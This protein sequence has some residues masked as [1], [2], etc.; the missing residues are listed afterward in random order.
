M[1]EKKTS[2]VKSN[3]IS[4]MSSTVG[5]AAG[6]V[7]G[8]V[9]SSEVNAAEVPVTP[10]EEREVE[11][12]SSQPSSTGGNTTHHNP[13]PT[14]APEPTPEPM[15]EPE[16]TPAP[17]PRPEPD[18]EP[19]P[20]PGP[21]PEPEIEVVSYE[22]VT[23]EDGSQMDVAVVNAHGQAVMIADVDQNGYADVMASDLNN[24]GQL[25]NGEIVDV[26]DQN[27]EMQP[28]REAVNMGGNDMIAQTN[29]VDYTNDA[30]VDDYIA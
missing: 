30:N 15:P 6:V 18:P 21:T 19:E 8:S 26:S 5:A 11:V 22:T 4:G 1:K 28:L 14:P 24:N 2:K 13:T 7:A 9:I 16:P 27:I 23:N 25:D 20:I 10:E 12:V 17:K 29:D 3:V